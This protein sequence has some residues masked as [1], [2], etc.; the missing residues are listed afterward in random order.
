MKSIFPAIHFTR[1]PEIERAYGVFRAT[2]N[3]RMTF[4]F[5]DGDAF[6]VDLED[7]H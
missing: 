7:Y 4:T 3:W 6:D 2:G 1:S 5:E